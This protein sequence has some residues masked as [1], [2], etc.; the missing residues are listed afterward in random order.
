M[1]RRGIIYP[2]AQIANSNTYLW[3]I[4]FPTFLWQYLESGCTY[5]YCERIDVMWEF[6]RPNVRISHQWNQ[7]LSPN[8]IMWELFLRM[9]RT[10][11][12]YALRQVHLPHPKLPN[13]KKPR[14]LYIYINLSHI[15]TLPSLF[16]RKPLCHKALLMWENRFNFLTLHPISLTLSHCFSHITPNQV[17]FPISLGCIF[18]F[19]RAS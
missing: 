10:V 15:I 4:Q 1:P 8:V 5:R 13:S 12:S 16:A 11:N 18:P 9:F 19:S 7:W 17:V 6:F 14:S 3:F 2:L